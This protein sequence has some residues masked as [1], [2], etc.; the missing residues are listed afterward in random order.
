[1]PTAYLVGVK[2]NW[3]RQELKIEKFETPEWPLTIRFPGAPGARLERGPTAAVFLTLLLVDA[4]DSQV[5]VAAAEREVRRNSGA[6]RLV[7][8]VWEGGWQ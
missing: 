1:M 4:V 7:G 6:A 5:G 8:T 3:E 2:T